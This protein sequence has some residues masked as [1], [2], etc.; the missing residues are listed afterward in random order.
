[1]PTYLLLL[2]RKIPFGVSLHTRSTSGCYIKSMS[3]ACLGDF[4]TTPSY[5][6]TPVVKYYIP[7]ITFLFGR[8]K[9]C[10]DPEQLLYYLTRSVPKWSKARMI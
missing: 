9:G 1:M 8:Y 4:T 2:R 5:Q 10:P 7:W 6:P 3:S